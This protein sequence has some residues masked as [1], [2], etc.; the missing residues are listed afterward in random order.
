MLG[1]IQWPRQGLK[2]NMKK[3]PNLKKKLRMREIEKLAVLEVP[4]SPINS[5][6]AQV[7]LPSVKK[8]LS[9]LYTITLWYRENILGKRP[10]VGYR[11]CEY[12]TNQLKKK[13][14]VFEC[15]C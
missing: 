1:W 14:W 4:P 11:P 8:D 13:Q 6:V 7:K 2:K 3:K 12:I 5:W 9:K 10:S 15:E